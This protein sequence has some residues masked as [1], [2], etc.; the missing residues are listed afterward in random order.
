MDA[1]ELRMALLCLT[2]FLVKRPGRSVGLA[3]ELGLLSWVMG[4]TIFTLLSKGGASPPTPS[5]ADACYL[6]MYPFAYF[7]IMLIMRGEVRA[8]KANTSLD[9]AVAS[10]GAAAICAV[11]VLDPIINS[12]SGSPAAV[13]VNLAYPIGDLILLAFAFVALVIVPG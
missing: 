8:F 3:F 1:F 12:V 7:G 4:D 13:T 11:F 6:T 2:R 10:L 5:L 9:G